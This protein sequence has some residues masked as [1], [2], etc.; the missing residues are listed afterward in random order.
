MAYVP[1]EMRGVGTEIDIDIRGRVVKG[2][3]RGFTVLF[4]GSG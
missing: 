4:P 3:H 1:T 2:A